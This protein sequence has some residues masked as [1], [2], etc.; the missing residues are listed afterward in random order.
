MC[1]WGC[2][3]GSGLGIDLG[4]MIFSYHLNVLPSFMYCNLILIEVVFRDRVFWEVNNMST[5][6]LFCSSAMG[7]HNICHFKSVLEPGT[8]LEVGIWPLADTKSTRLQTLDFPN[9]R[10]IRNKFLLFINYTVCS[11]GYR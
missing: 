10:T 6:L 8:L 9:S 11:F 4:H 5:L 3:R 7:K 1:F 2:R